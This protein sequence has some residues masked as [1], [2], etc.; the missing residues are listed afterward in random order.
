MNKKKALSLLLATAMV[1][2]MNTISFAAE[3]T[4]TV[5]EQMVYD[6]YSMSKNMQSENAKT[7]SANAKVYEEAAKAGIYFGTGVVDHV[8]ATGSKITSKQIVGTKGYY[9]MVV[10]ANGYIASVKAVKVT[11]KTKAAG[12]TVTYKIKKLNLGKGVKK[13]E[14]VDSYGYYS[15]SDLVGKDAKEGA[16]AMKSILSTLKGYEF[17]A[18]IYPTYISGAVSSNFA[19]D[20][21]K[22]G[23]T[24]SSGDA[25]KINDKVVVTKKNG[26]V[27]KVQVVVETSIKTNGLRSGEKTTSDDYSIIKFKTLKKGKDYEVTSDGA[28]D[29][30]VSDKYYSVKTESGNFATKDFA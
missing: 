16:K 12:E 6:D 2:T 7:E 15:Y 11:S 8:K 19:K 5:E 13:F 3:K 21:L 22:N 28:I 17:S 9:T 4:S 30:K 26:N 18:N 20:I 24:V 1:F 27:K 10:S 23:K 14:S 29:L 25:N